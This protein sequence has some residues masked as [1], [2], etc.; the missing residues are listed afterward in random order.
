MS[1]SIA[2]IQHSLSKALNAMPGVFS[3]VQWGG[4]AYKLPGPGSRGKK[5]PVLL[6]HVCLN[7]AGDAVCLGFRLE[8]PR[9]LA[10]IKQ[11]D[12]IKVN[13]FGSLGRSGWVEMAISTK[14]QCK[15]TIALLRES[16]SLHATN[17]DDSEKRGARKKTSRKGKT[18]SVAQGSA[19]AV[20]RRLDTILHQKRA[21]G[22]R[23]DRDG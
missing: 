18:Q 7:K 2:S 14:S 5:R 3:T 10:V 4:R 8:K 13:S 11:H 16:H 20:A 17:E 1:K 12:W 22:W 23:P 15:I 19:V 6:T 21:E 9:A